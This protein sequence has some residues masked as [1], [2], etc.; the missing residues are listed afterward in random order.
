MNLKVSTKVEE[1]RANDLNL[2]TKDEGLRTK[3]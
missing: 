1:L 2:R 3:D